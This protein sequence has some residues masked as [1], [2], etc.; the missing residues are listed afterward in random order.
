MAAPSL[1]FSKAGLD[2]ALEQP[3]IVEAMI[4]VSIKAVGNVFG[5]FK[6][7]GTARTP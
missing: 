6:S 7:A 1:E 2:G 4:S 5:V 3:G